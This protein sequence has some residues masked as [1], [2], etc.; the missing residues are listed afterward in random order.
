M[1]PGPRIRLACLIVALQSVAACAVPF[2]AKA[3]DMIDVGDREDITIDL[4]E[5]KV[6]SD[7]GSRSDSVASFDG[8]RRFVVH[9]PD[10]TID[11]EYDEVV[12][13]ELSAQPPQPFQAVS[14][15]NVA[16]DVDEVQ[17]LFDRVRN[18][19]PVEGDLLD[20]LNAFEADFN[21]KVAARG[22]RIDIGDFQRSSG[23]AIHDL[24]L[25]VAEESRAALKWRVF[26]DGDVLFSVD[27]QF[28][29][30]T[31]PNWVG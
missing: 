18:E 1:N 14:L 19:F 25:W 3:G 23:S 27:I 24:G 8:P 13:L 31:D 5:P 20:A 26:T 16:H 17:M 22:G 7:F 28:D 12:L 6:G 15:K 11:G 4:R 2:G 9:L 30:G 29:N 21:A 10:R